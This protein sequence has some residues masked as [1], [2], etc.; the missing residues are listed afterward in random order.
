LYVP[1]VYVGWHTVTV[2]DHWGYCWESD[3][4]VSHFH[5]VVLDRQVVHTRPGVASKYK[6]ER[7]VGY[8][9]PVSHGY[10]D[11]D[12]KKLTSAT[13]S[14]PAADA[15]KPKAQSRTKTIRTDKADR[16]QSK[17]YTRG[18]TEV[19]KTDRG[20]QTA[21]LT[22][23]DVSKRARSSRS[24]WE[25]RQ[26]TKLQ[27]TKRWGG[28]DN[29]AGRSS[30]KSSRSSGYEYDARSGSKRSHA[31]PRRD[32]DRYKT[33]T[34]RKSES[35]GFYRKKSGST[36]RPTIDR[37]PSQRKR[38][39]QPSIKRSKPSSS[40][41]GKRIKPSTGGSKTGGATKARPKSS[42]GGSKGKSTSKSSGKK[43]R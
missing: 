23:T 43:G 20:I 41:S 8:R 17:R 35:S 3:V 21:G 24:D 14:G 18:T 22:R 16:S 11:F 26:S 1:R 27:P 32:A 25:R 30:G 2:Y 38:E 29:D 34:P 12:K 6:E 10:P 28:A 19:I 7:S 13:I 42:S 4:H 15:N 9:N 40:G 31:T 33:H 36:K 37:K 39:A 5:T